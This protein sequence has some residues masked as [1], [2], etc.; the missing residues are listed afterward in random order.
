[1]LRDYIDLMLFLKNNIDPISGNAIAKQKKM[2]NTTAQS[3]LQELERV[4]L[5]EK[6]YQSKHMNLWTITYNGKAVLELL[7]IFEEF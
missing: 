7:T 3:R 1:M 2:F 6:V 4:G 5:V